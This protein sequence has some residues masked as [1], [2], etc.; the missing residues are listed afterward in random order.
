MFG[1][2]HHTGKIKQKGVDKQRYK[3]IMVV[4]PFNP[5]KSLIAQYIERSVN[6]NSH[7]TGRTLNFHKNS[8]KRSNITSHNLKIKII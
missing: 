6:A 7:F 8:G 1:R 5:V 3:N 4:Y 2:E